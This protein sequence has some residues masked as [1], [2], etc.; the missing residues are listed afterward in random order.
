MGDHSKISNAERAGRWL[1]GAYRGLKVQEQRLRLWLVGLGVP[2]TG[3]RLL[4][5]CLWLC[6]LALLLSISIVLAMII[7]VL[8]LTGRGI[9]RSDLTYRIPD[10]EWR[11]GCSG[12]GL[13]THDE[14]RIDPHVFEDD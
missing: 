2:L 6:V 4:S 8:W 1:G 11:N 3:A 13:Y 9:A 7:C 14:L 10:A 5:W 12:Y